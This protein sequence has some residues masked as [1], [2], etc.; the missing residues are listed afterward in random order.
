MASNDPRARYRWDPLTAQYRAPNGQF[1]TRREVVRALD[2]ALNSEAAAMARNFVLLREGTLTLDA[3][4]LAMRQSI[5]LM[6]LWAASAA[7][8]GWAQLLP[9]DYGRVGATVAFHYGRLQRFALQL[10]A[11]LP[12]DGRA[13]WRVSMYARA[14]RQTYHAVELVTTRAAGYAFELNVLNA[15]SESC[16][17][18]VSLTESGLQPIGTMP[19]PGR[20]ACLT[21]CTCYFEFFLRRD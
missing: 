8:G 16:G 13:A 2:G 10:A 9:A 20:R 17:Q 6:H 19:R 5:K 1:V 12:L 3:W 21:G 18:C 11:G 4:H 7:K 15:A 14:A